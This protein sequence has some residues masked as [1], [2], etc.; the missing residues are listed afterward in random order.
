MSVFP[1]IK[2]SFRSPSLPRAGTQD[3]GATIAKV[4]WQRKGLVFE[5]ALIQGLEGIEA[6]ILA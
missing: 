4:T 5:A 1:E 3:I 2:K 6:N